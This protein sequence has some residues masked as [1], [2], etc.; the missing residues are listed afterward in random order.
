[1]AMND[2]KLWTVVFETEQGE[3]EQFRVVAE[4]PSEVIDLLK[5]QFGDNVRAA[6]PER[7]E[8]PLTER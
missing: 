1:M 4:T 2:R 3:L 6:E 7:V 5:A 8:G